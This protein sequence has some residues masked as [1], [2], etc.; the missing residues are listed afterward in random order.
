MPVS[1][2]LTTHMESPKAVDTLKMTE[3]N[4]PKVKTQKN[5][6]VIKSEEMTK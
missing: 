3:V 1:A 5:K 2:F 4:V 6:P